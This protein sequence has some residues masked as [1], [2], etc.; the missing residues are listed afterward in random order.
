[1]SVD[2]RLRAGLGA[3]ARAL[4]EPDVEL[5]LGKAR[6]THRR[7]RTL[8]GAGLATLAAAACTALVLALVWQP[9]QA[10]SPPVGRTP[11]TLQGVYAG[12]VPALPGAPRASGRWAL[13]FGVDGLVVA[14]AP[15]SYGQGVPQVIGSTDGRTVL[16]EVFEDVL[17]QGSGSGKYT[18][19]RRGDHLVLDPVFDSCTS[20]VL[21]FTSPTWISSDA[22]TA[23]GQRIP[24]GR[25]AREVT[26]SDLNRVGFQPD[27]AWLASNGLRD[28]AGRFVIEIEG[29]RWFIFVETDQGALELGDQGSVE[30]DA[31]GRWVLTGDVVP[32]FSANSVEWIVTLVRMLGELG[33][34]AA[35]VNTGLQGDGLRRV[36]ERVGAAAHVVSA[37]LAPRLLSAL[38]VGRGPVVVTGPIDSETVAVAGSPDVQLLPFGDLPR[39]RAAGRTGLASHPSDL[40]LLVFTSGT[41][42]STPSACVFSNE[43]VARQGEIITEWLG[44]TPD[45]VLFCSF[46]LF[47]VI[48]STV[49]VLPAL[50]NRCVAA[51]EQRF[52]RS[53]SGIGFGRLERP[54]RRSSARP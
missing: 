23:S 44:V 19:T 20:R 43:Y 31:L 37:S 18:A 10:V 40:G 13:S 21:F 32:I 45:D 49:T 35:G 42:G 9:N 1:M 4:P 22:S 41:S 16:T 24:E 53:H 51:I 25:W 17:C 8:R 6:A 36:L 34:A 33:A 28:G 38:P 39:G 26:V 47:H 30:Y 52:E 27:A 50:L 14:T 7:R 5:I 3:N 46:P 2:D 11:A 54:S 29:S 48:G 15:N 12:L